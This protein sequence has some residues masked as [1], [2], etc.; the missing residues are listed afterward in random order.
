MEIT[1]TLY[2]YNMT[3]VNPTISLV[4]ASSISDF[5]QDGS[6]YGYGI[7]IQAIWLISSK[8]KINALR[9][10]AYLGSCQTSN[11]ELLVK[12]IEGFNG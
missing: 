5:Q 11:M 9:S 7:N 4:K 12:I 1:K 2:G 3:L 8:M 6:N 10:G